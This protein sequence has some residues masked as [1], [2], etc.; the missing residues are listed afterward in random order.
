MD[1]IRRDR[2]TVNASAR[3][4]RERKTDLNG[5]VRMGM[6]MDRTIDGSSDQHRLRFT[7]KSPNPNNM[8]RTMFWT[9][10]R[11]RQNVDDDVHLH[12]IEDEPIEL[13]SYLGGPLD[14]SVLIGYAHHWSGAC[15][16]E[17]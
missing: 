10:M 6:D 7:S 12:V 9:M 5:K 14:M 3:R 15:G 2:P 16:M 4:Q 17:K 11:R 1:R 13:K 8:L